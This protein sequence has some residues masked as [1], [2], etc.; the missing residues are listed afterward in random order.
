VASGNEP[1][2]HSEATFS[3]KTSGVGEVSV[4]EGKGL[5]GTGRTKLLPRCITKA[6]ENHKRLMGTLIRCSQEIDKKWVQRLRSD[7][8][9]TVKPAV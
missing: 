2:N 5:Q 9:I 3:L 7:K 1:V 6:D 4:V 8:H